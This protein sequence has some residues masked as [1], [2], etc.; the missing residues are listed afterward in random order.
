VIA[1]W[2]S[3]GDLIMLDD[4]A[5]SGMAAGF[6]SAAGFRSGAGLTSAITAA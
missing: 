6:L 3:A 4:A 1:D 5:F 2:S